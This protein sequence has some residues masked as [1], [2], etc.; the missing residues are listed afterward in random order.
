MFTHESKSIFTEFF[1]QTPTKIVVSTAELISASMMQLMLQTPP[2]H[3]LSQLD[4]Q[5]SSKAIKKEIQI[6]GKGQNETLEIVKPLV[7]TRSVTDA[8]KTHVPGNGGTCQFTC[9]S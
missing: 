9:G 4:F 3:S 5:K 6:V 8:V 1:A 2:N 7:H